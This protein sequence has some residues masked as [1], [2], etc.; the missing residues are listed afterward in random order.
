MAG[1]LALKKFIKILEKQLVCAYLSFILLLAATR[2]AISS[3][4]SSY[5][6][7]VF[8]RL[9]KDTSAAH[10]IEQVGESTTVNEDLKYHVMSF[11]Q[12]IRIMWKN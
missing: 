7:R 1:L 12:K 9:L 10:L 5:Q 4:T 3:K 6:K 2:S 8:Q 11:I